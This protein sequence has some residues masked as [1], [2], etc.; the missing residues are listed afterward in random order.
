MQ[1]QVRVRV[2]HDEL[3]ANIE[4]T[5]RAHTG[6]QSFESALLTRRATETGGDLDPGNMQRTR[7]GILVG[8]NGRRA[9][10][11][12]WS[13]HGC[14]AVVDAEIVDLK[15]M[16]PVSRSSTERHTV[17][18]AYDGGSGLEAA[19]RE[20]PEVIVCDIGLPAMDGY[21]LARTLRSAPLLA[22]CL[23]VA[24]TGYGELRD[25]DRG[26]EAGFDHY[27]V[28]PADPEEIAELLATHVTGHERKGGAS[29]R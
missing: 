3:I 2:G 1:H 28:K 21:A 12:K 24:V 4:R 16:A 23:L 20:R 26:Q 9:R 5:A 7:G 29:A 11:R 15:V 22:N 14:L 8:P 6:D 13:I 17:H 19:L 27:L 25:K 18:V 10:I